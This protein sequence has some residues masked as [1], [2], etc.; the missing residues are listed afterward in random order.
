MRLLF[1]DDLI[2][3]SGSGPAGKARLVRCHAADIQ[4]GGDGSRQTDSGQRLLLSLPVHWLLVPVLQRCVDMASRF[5]WR[6]RLEGVTPLDRVNRLRVFAVLVNSLSLCSWASVTHQAWLTHSPSIGK[7]LKI[8][9]DDMTIGQHDR[10]ST[11]TDTH[12][13][14]NSMMSP[15]SLSVSYLLIFRLAQLPVLTSRHKLQRSQGQAT[16][17]TMWRKLKL[18]R[19]NGA[20]MMCV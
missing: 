18:G 13:S 7:S 14:T 5:R 4:A 10:A 19:S 1:S 11:H 17:T 15:L 16:R 6:V 12:S 9:D 2:G 20:A 8:K 3:L